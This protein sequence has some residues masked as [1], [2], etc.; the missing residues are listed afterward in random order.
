MRLLVAGAHGQLGSEL[1]RL[2][3]QHIVL[4][5][6]YQDLDITDAEAVK[7]T[8]SEFKP[9]AIINAAAYTAVDRAESERDQAFAVNCDG[10]KHLAL[11]AELASIPLIHVST[12][13]V[14]AGSKSA[15]YVEADAVGPLAVYGASKLAGEEAVQ[16]HCSRSIIL[17]TSWVFSAHGNNFVKTMLRLAQERETLGIVADQHGCPTS[18]AEL[19]RAIYAVLD[20]HVNEKNWGVYHFC[21]PEATTWF[22]F[23]S[24]IFKEA[25]IQGVA[26]KVSDVKAIATSDYPTPAKRP[27]NSVMNCVKFAQ[28]FDFTIRPWSE[29]LKEVIEELQNV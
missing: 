3:D 20:A 19:A 17:R 14:Y 27:V 24:A 16:R 25:R 22:A 9:D 18:A 13:Y 28:T 1:V 23:A 10:A 12:D 15:A 8:V 21:Q 2:G 11:A 29:S 5:V 6:D 7:S 26:L 4:A